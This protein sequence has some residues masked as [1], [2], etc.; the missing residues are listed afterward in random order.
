MPDL[1]AGALGLGGGGGGVAVRGL[2]GLL[3]GGGAL[4][5][6][7]GDALAVLGRGVQ[8]P[9]EVGGGLGAGGERGGGVPLGLA[10]GGGDPRGAVGGGAVPQHGL[11]GLPGGVQRTGVGELAALRGGAPSPRRPAPARRAGRRVRRRSG[12]C[13]RGPPRRAVT[14]V[15]G[16]G[17]LLGEVGGAAALLGAAG[18]QPPGERAGAPLG[19]RVDVAGACTRARRPRRSGR[20]GRRSRR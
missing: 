15:R 7:V 14:R 8:G 6:L 17:D 11:G 19:A 1:A 20:A 3:E 4:L 2:A 9:Y 16:G 12:R 10:D 5:L 13:G 18:G